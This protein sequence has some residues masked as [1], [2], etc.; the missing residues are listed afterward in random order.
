MKIV[1]ANQDAVASI[2]VA[3]LDRIFVVMSMNFY[4]DLGYTSDGLLMRLLFVA[5][6]LLVMRKPSVGNMLP[7]QVQNAH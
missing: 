4:I 7:T 3:D 5:V 1:I 6:C 2:T